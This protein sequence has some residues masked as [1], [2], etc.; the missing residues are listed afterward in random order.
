MIM[1]LALSASN[2]SWLISN[3]ASRPSDTRWWYMYVQY[4]YVEFVTGARSALGV[5]GGGLGEGRW[6]GWCW[7]TPWVEV[8]GEV[9][10]VAQSVWKTFCFQKVMGSN[11]VGDSCHVRPCP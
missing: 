2:N 7:R 10:T 6:Y 1:W 5:G 11:P 8:G 4:A 3:T 9:V